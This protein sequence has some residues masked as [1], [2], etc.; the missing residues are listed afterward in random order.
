[1]SKNFASQGSRLDRFANMKKENG[2]EI[3][4]RRVSLTE[5]DLEKKAAGPK[6]KVLVKTSIKIDRDLKEKSMALARLKQMT[7]ISLI[8]RGLEN[9]LKANAKLMNQ[10]TKYHI[11]ESNSPNE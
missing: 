4:G 3:A 5:D 8:E 6:A 2:A 10:F 9:Q 1:M 7:W 11:D